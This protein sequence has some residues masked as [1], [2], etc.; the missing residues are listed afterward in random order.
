ML[1]KRY[2]RIKRNLSNY[3]FHIVSLTTLFMLLFLLGRAAYK[4]HIKYSYAKEKADYLLIK[5]SVAEDRYNA[6][7][8]KLTYMKTRRGREDVL[9][10]TYGLAK[11]GENVLIIIKQEASS[12]PLQSEKSGIFVNV[13]NYIK[14]I[15]K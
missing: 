14:S 3:L 10:N 6:L 5:K 1:K 13:K 2:K 4:A 12:Y 7:Q 9:R 15:F 8:D 11:P